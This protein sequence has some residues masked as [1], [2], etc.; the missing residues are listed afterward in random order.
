MS[1]ETPCPASPVS[2]PALSP[3]GEAMVAALKRREAAETRIAVPRKIACE[4]LG[5]GPSREIELELEGELQSYLDGNVRRILVSSIY[6][7]LIRLAIV[8]HPLE[9]PPLKARSPAAQFKTAKRPVRPRTPAEL[10]GLAVGNA[11]RAEAA[12]LRREA[13]AK[14][15][16][17]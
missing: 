6:A 9:A 1:D 13:K 5:I 15:P 16:V 10:R 14:G 11:K 8:A 2:V 4:M 7:R 12:R 17:P 3:I